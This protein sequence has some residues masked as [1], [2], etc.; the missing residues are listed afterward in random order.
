[1]RVAPLSGAI[2]L[3]AAVSVGGL[4]GWRLWRA[5]RPTASAAEATP[6]ASVAEP[7]AT[8]EVER[9]EGLLLSG[10]VQA[11]TIDPRHWRVVATPLS[12]SISDGV[13]SAELSTRGRFD[14]YGLA[15]TD[16]RIELVADGSPP[17]V[18]AQADYVRPGQGELVLELDPLQLPR[19]AGAARAGE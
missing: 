14:L 12:L 11:R 7:E 9:P 13:R 17:Q 1:M 8:E 15:D 4:V 18:L 3:C 5:P 6:A 19:L 16:Y 10:F 2:L